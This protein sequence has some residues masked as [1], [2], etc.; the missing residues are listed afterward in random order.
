MPETTSSPAWMWLT[1]IFS[2]AERI[3]EKHVALVHTQQ[4][5]T[6]MGWAAV[7]LRAALAAEGALHATQRNILVDV[8]S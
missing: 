6:P 4:R 1:V 2:G 3:R 8:C 5:P 7:V